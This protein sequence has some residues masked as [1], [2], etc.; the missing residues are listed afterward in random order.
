ME[1]LN[2]FG[3]LIELEGEKSYHF[4]ALDDSYT[5]EFRENTVGTLY[6]LL[7][8]NRETEITF[9]LKRDCNIKMVLTAFGTA[10]YSIKFNV[11]DNAN[12]NLFTSDSFIYDVKINKTVNLLNEYA[13]YKGYEYIYS[14]GLKID[15]TFEVNH[16]AKN[17]KANGTFTYLGK[18][19][20]VIDRN[21]VSRIEKGMDNADS[22]EN[23]RGLMLDPHSRIN[24][25]PV[26]II[27][28]DEV[29][30]AHGC[31]IG[32]IDQNEVYYLMS[33]GLTREDAM[34]IICRSLVNPIIREIKDNEYLKIAKPII[35]ATIGE[36]EH[37]HEHD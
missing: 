33:R 32:T 1:L 5:Y 21:V 23:I 11:M 22:S 8:I 13:Q 30:A 3:S 6:L 31:A 7:E 18:G 36:R 2:D 26:L 25:K 16:L 4:Q 34:K 24:A 10:P 15:G 37:E 14:N 28:H 17:T 20:C 27:S 29:K 19:E 35:E 9:N 12:L